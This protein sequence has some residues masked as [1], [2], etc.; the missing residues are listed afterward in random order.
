LE[1]VHFIRTRISKQML[2]WA[3]IHS[4]QQYSFAGS[5]TLVFASGAGLCPGQPQWCGEQGFERPRRGTEIMDAA[6]ARETVN[7]STTSPAWSRR[8]ACKPASGAT[9]SSLAETAERW[10]AAAWEAS[11]S[12][13]NGA[14][15]PANGEWN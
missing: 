6:L 12:I 13:R 9:L 11:S 5:I 15:I 1:T 3:E 8:S 10:P 2:A 7:G 4:E 14:G